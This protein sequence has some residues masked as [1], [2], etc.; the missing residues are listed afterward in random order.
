MTG[1]PEFWLVLTIGCAECG[2]EPLAH[3]VGAALSLEAGKEVAPTLQGYSAWK[4]HPQGGEI[5][6]SGSGGVW[7]MPSR[8]LTL[9]PVPPPTNRLTT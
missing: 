6:Q 2:D 8:Y 1:M 9:G 3:V 5:R 4:P 7:V